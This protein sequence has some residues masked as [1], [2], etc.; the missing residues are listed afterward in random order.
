MPLSGVRD[1]MGP[2]S[3]TRVCTGVEGDLRG[4]STGLELD[5]TGAGVAVES[6]ADIKTVVLFRS[7]EL[8]LVIN[9]GQA[10]IPVG[11]V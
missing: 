11:E 2:A 9:G 6:I 5:A 4:V 1:R 7:Y 8:C 10:M 3:R